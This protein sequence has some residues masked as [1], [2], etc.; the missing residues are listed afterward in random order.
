MGGAAATADE[1]AFVFVAQVKQWV[2]VADTFTTVVSLELV[3]KLCT[4]AVIAVDALV[5]GLTALQASVL[6][7]LHLWLFLTCP[8]Q[9]SRYFHLQKQLSLHASIAVVDVVFFAESVVLS[10]WV[11]AKSGPTHPLTQLPMRKVDGMV[12]SLLL[13]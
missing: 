8:I 13:I 3:S 11:E 9:L 4:V 10:D 1:E 2:L 12:S 6:A 5:R 7:L